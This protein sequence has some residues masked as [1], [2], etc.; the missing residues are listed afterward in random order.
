MDK[1]LRAKEPDDAVLTPEDE[2][3]IAEVTVTGRSEL[4]S[5]LERVFGGADWPQVSA[6]VESF[7]QYATKVFDVNATVYRKAASAQG[8]TLTIF[9]VQ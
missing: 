9:S 8:R 2:L 7:R 3:R 5:E 6:V 4:R 1:S